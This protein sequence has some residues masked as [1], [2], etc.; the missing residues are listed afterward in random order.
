MNKEKIRK[1]IKAITG[2]KKTVVLT[3][4]GISTES[5]IPDFRSPGGIW[6]RFDPAVM[7]AEVLNRDPAYFY[8]KAVPMLEFFGEIADKKPNPAHFVLRDMEK[9]R[10]ISSIITQNIDGL[11]TKAGSENVYEVHGS[12]RE[13][14]CMTCGKRVS[15]NLLADR[16]KNNEIPPTCESCGGILRPDVVLFGEELPAC[17]NIAVTEVESSGL[18]LIVGSSLEIIPVGSLPDFAGRYIILN[19]GR[20]LYDNGAYATLDEKAGNSLKVIYNEIK[21]I[22]KRL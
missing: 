10:L 19:K 21:N 9:D 6:S 5:G 18:L 20:T 8:R 4:A 22:E 13:G 16:V 3:G 1:I 15:F 11:H 14:Y 12:L 7:S 17:F 2:S